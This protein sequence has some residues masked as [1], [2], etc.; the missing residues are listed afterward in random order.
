MCSL[1]RLDNYN[2]KVTSVAFSPNGEYIASGS[3]EEIGIWM[4]SNGEL[5][6][7]FTGLSD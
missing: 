5:I 3:Y 6:K 7:I 4:I 1:I 2:R